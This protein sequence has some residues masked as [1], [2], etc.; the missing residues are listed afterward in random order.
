MSRPQLNHGDLKERSERLS[1]LLCTDYLPPGGGGVEVVVETLATHLVD[2]GVD[3]TVIVPEAVDGTTPSLSSV[4]GVHLYEIPSVN[5]TDVIGLQ[6]QISPRALSQLQAVVTRHDPDIIHVHNRFF[7]TSLA[8][9]VWK[10]VSRT[11]VPLVTTFHLGPIDDVGGA[12]GY[13]ARL[14]EQLAGRLL[15]RMSD[16]V[17]AVSNAVAA[18]VQT[19]GSVS[20]IPRVVPNGVD[21]QKFVPDTTDPNNRGKQILFVGRLVRNKGPQVLIEALPQVLNAHPDATVE[22]VGTGP[23]ADEL[24]TRTEELGVDHAVHFQ[25][26]VD[27]VAEAMRD[28]DVFCRPSFSEGMPL[29]LLEAMASGLPAIVTPVAGVSEVVTDSETGIL[30]D[31]DNPQELAVALINILNNPDLAA[32]IGRQARAHVIE[33]YEWKQRT[34]QILDIYEEIVATQNKT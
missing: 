29:T 1:V 22:I 11:D 23:M 32:K 6:C 28:S 14:Y 21:P 5:I 26:Y 7:F 2:Y 31:R 30:V 25:G 17:I 13:I 33:N 20:T 19:L 8:A 12:A 27:S 10:L 24:K 9:A 34:K 15:L 16:T 4:E 18:H 3:I